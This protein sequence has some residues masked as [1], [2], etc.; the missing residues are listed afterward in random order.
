MAGKHR[1]D[2][3]SNKPDGYRGKHRAGGL[4]DTT[5][6]VRVEL[7]AK[8]RVTGFSAGRQIEDRGYHRE[9]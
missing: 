7:D 9:S 6:E 3:T 2:N 8:H 5:A 1:S 4:K